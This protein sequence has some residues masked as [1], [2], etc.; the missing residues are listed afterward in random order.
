MTAETCTACGGTILPPASSG[1]ERGS[2]HCPKGP[3]R[4]KARMLYSTE[5]TPAHTVY[6]VQWE[7]GIHEVQPPTLDRAVAL[8]MALRKAWWSIHE[9]SYW[10]ATCEQMIR[11]SP[12]CSEAQHKVQCGK[13]Q[14]APGGS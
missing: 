12:W 1:A 5:S 2:C 13:P 11:R 3:G 10:C 7:D 6:S 9:D 14:P 4:I 8:L